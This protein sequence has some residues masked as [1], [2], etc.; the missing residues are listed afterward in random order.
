[1]LCTMSNNLECGMKNVE[2]GVMHKSEKQELMCNIFHRLYKSWN[3]S[4]GI[5]K[6]SVIVKHV[7]KGIIVDSK[8]QMCK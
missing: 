6:K 4:M 7:G 2:S 3:V 1:M 8:K 5:G